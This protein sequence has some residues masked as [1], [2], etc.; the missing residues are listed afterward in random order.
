[1][2][3]PRF[4]D[5]VPLREGHRLEGFSC[6]RTELDHWLA[7]YAQISQAARTGRT[8]VVTDAQSAMRVV[9]YYSLAA[10]QVRREEAHER[11][12][13]GVPRHPVPVVVLTRLA[14]DSTVQGMGVGTWMLRD[15]L[16]RVKASSENLGIRAVIVHASNEDAK[17]FYEARGFAPSPT[18]PLNL[19]LLLKDIR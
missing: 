19:Q 8:F 10:G 14:V 2:T 16:L 15:A 12:A 9:G 3:A 6:G 1:M 7:D 13:K 5:P 18:D 4:A 17:A 11:V